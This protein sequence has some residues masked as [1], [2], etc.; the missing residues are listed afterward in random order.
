MPARVRFLGSVA[1]NRALRRMALAYL[2]FTMAEYAQWIAIL[3]FAYARG[4]PRAMATIS[5]VQLVPAAVV[6][7]IA[8]YAGDRFRRDRVLSLQYI[9]QAVTLGLT[10]V[11]LLGDAP[12]AVIYLA[13]AASA[14]S[15]TFT[16]PTHSALLPGVTDRPQDLTAANVATGLAEGLGIMLGPAAAG[17]LLGVGGSGVVFVTFAGTSV[18]AAILVSRLPV[19]ADRVT[20]RAATAGSTVWRQA[21]AGFSA[22]RGEGDV[23]TIIALLGSAILVGG[24]LDVLFVAAAIDLLHLGE[25]GAGFLSAAFG[26]GAVVG[27]GITVALVGRRRLTPPLAGGAGV[28]GLP[29]AILAAIP[30]AVAAPVLFALGGAG[31]RVADVAGRTLLQ[32]VAP[33]HTLTRVFGVLEGIGM[34]ALAIGSV[35]ASGLVE[36]FGIRAT[37]VA[38]GAFVPLVV[39]LLARRLLAIDRDAAAPDPVALDLIRGLDLFAPLPPEAIERVLRSLERIDVASGTTVIREGDVGDRFYVIADGDADVTIGG[40]SV[41]SLGRGEAFGEIALLRDVPRVAS[42]TASTSMSLLALDREPFLA[43]VTGHPQSLRAAD[44]LAAHR[45]SGRT[46]TTDGAS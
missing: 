38:T 44:A 46:T 6:A 5:I 12:L 25:S 11:A 22:L 32:R 43:A 15:L 20:P 16:R 26:A 28:F 27:A 24:A 31:R 13:A 9:V 30:T 18:I 19:D 45:L 3:V 7:P 42:V 33:D 29:V 4:G 10:G 36:A 23:R 8:A 41:A 2:A 40:R 1:R 37:L 21:I 34:L 14:A 35:A 17:I 39:L